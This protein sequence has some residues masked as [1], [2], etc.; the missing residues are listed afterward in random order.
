MNKVNFNAQAYEKFYDFKDV[1]VQ[2]FGIG[3]SLCGTEEIEYVYQNHP[4]TIG[5]LIKNQAKNLTDQEVDQLI[6]KPLLNWQTFDETNANQ[7]IPTFLCV[8]CFDI[9]SD[10]DEK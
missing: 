9:E 7:M 10:Y 2:A 5:N 4:P 6:E 3:C 8:N 1:M